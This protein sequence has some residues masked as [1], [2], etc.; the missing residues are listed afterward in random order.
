MS[1]PKTK[2]EESLLSPTEIAKTHTNVDSTATT[3]AISNLLIKEHSSAWDEVQKH[4]SEIF[5]YKTPPEKVKKRPDGFDY[6]SGQYMDYIFK[7][8][9]PLYKYQLLHVSFE[10]GWVSIIVSLEDRLTG[11]VELGAGAARIQVPRGVETPSF[12]DIIDLGNNMKAA[13]SSAIKNAQARFGVAADVHKRREGVATEEE[14]KRYEVILEQLKTLA[15]NRVELFSQGWKELG[16]EF[17]EYL[18][19]W[20]TYVERLQNKSK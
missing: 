6:V 19:K 5:D 15:P 9:S 12:R 14:R 8:H 17:S 11:N 2:V 1:E 4:V 13:L 3:Q 16:D 10:Y 20:E 7:Q 18:F